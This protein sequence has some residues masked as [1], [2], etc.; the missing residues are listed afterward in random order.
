MKCRDVYLHIC[1]NLDQKLNSRECMEVKRHL[2]RCPDCRVY[3]DTLKRTVHLYQI[4]RAP[5]VTPRTHRNLRKAIDLAWNTAPR[6]KEKSPSH[7]VVMRRRT[8]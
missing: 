5:N 1:D 4:A 2:D 6:E 3:L 8:R 7:R